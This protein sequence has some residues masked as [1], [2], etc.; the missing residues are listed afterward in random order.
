MT[1]LFA[2]TIPLR[3]HRSETVPDPIEPTVA[4]TFVKGDGGISGRPGL[5]NPPSPPFAKEGMEHAIENYH[6]DAVP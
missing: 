6:F 5:A 4:P 3:L 2:R 1:G